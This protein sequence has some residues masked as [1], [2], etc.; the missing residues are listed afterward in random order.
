MIDKTFI[1]YRADIVLTSSRLV[2]RG[3]IYAYMS[4]KQSKATKK[5][6][7][8]MP[9][10]SAAVFCVCIDAT[11]HSQPVRCRGCGERQGVQEENEDTQEKKRDTKDTSPRKKDWLAMHV[12][13][14]PPLRQCECLA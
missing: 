6:A 7:C 11:T 2:R 9:A 12:T 4:H 1:Y 8:I 5:T 13:L 14:A 3:R 10:P